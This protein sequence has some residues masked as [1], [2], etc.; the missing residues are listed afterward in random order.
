MGL[1]TIRVY[2]QCEVCEGRGLIEQEGRTFDC[3]TCQGYG[4][5]FEFEERCVQIEQLPTGD[6]R[7]TGREIR[8][9]VIPF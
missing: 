7:I 4:E 9:E 6:V 2:K 5:T 8:V 3:R 1:K